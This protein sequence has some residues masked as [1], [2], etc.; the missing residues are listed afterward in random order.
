M[1]AMRKRG[2]AGGE[3]P[4][5]RGL[6]ADAAGS[7]SRLFGTWVVLLGLLIGLSLVKLGNPVVLGHLVP[8]PLVAGDW[9]RFAWPPG[10]FNWVPIV[11]LGVGVWGCRAG[12]MQWGSLWREHRSLLLLAGLWLFW[13]A[14]AVAGSIDRGMSGRVWWHYAG[15]VAC[16]GCGVVLA[17]G[18]RRWMG[19]F[20]VPLAVG[21]FW[22][23]L[24]GFNQ[25]YGGLEATRKFVYEQPGWESFPPE[26][27][28]RLERDR[29]FG[30]LF[31]ANAMAGV[32]LLLLPGTL[33]FC[34]RVGSERLRVFRAVAVGLSAYAGLACLYW[35]G[36]K[37]GWLIAVVVLSVAFL[38]LPLG[39]RARVVLV[40]LG[41]VVALTAFGIRYREYFRG[42]ATS[43]VAR[44]D[45]W[46]VAV[47]NVKSRPF[48]GSGPGTFE[49]VYRQGK[50]PE[51][52][53]SRLVHNDYLQQ[54][55]D[56]GLPGGLLFALWVGMAMLRGYRLA[57]GDLL[58]GL[59]WLGLLGW[60]LQE[61]VE[62]GLFIPGIGWP[63]MVLLGWVST[64]QHSHRQ[65][66]VGSLV[67]PRR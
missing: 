43:V 13:Q 18:G 52:E 50:K 12:G 4:G 27:L 38:H 11:L 66:G 15:I 65:P 40:V 31:Y 3:V 55:S 49:Q 59:L 62:F 14:L 63:A 58:R 30:T 60:C 56:S 5:G 7:G 16:Y 32:I 24:E 10:I 45:Y 42:G 35:T 8:R 47:S 64:R 2:R 39:R 51:A 26:F 48:L 1:G 20:W 23:L 46:A 22:A 6:E 33:W 41:S 67:S 61:F 36:S 25:H 17:A 28:K 34:S 21:F 37:A 57:G 29:V 19:W 54:A 9:L 44:F 53:M